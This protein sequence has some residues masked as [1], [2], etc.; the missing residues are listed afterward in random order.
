LPVPA[1]VPPVPAVVPPVPAV[2]PPVP[3]V[4]PPLPAVAVPPLPPE[5]LPPELLPPELVP[6]VLEPALPAIEL[7]PAVPPVAGSSSLHATTHD[8]AAAEENV[9]ARS[10][11]V[12]HNFIL[13]L[14]Q[15]LIRLRHPLDG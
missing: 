8:I 4:V 9:K 11:F 14:I 12:E 6:A 13:A 7:L 1:V 15:F 5:L 2:V 3:A 10:T